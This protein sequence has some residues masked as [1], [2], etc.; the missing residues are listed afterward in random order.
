MCL[1]S[2]KTFC[3]PPFRVLRPAIISAGR[4]FPADWAFP[5]RPVHYGADLAAHQ[6]PIAAAV[7]CGRPAGCFDRCFDPVFILPEQARRHPPYCGSPGRSRARSENKGV[8]PL[9][10]S[11]CNTSLNMDFREEVSADRDD[12]QQKQAPPSQTSAW[13]GGYGMASLVSRRGMRG[14]PRDP[15]AGNF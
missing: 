8:L 12:F 5:S 2:C 11:I 3:V 4:P 15:C 1:I 13:E 9:V 10:F 14:F 7:G 6:R